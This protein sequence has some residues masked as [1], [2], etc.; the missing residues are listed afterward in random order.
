[1]RKSITMS[2]SLLL[3]LVLSGP[4]TAQKIKTEDGIKIISNGSKPKPQK[5]VPSK[6][7]FT[8]ELRFGEGDDPETSFSQV[9]FFVVTDEGHVIAGDIKDKKVKVFD[10]EGNFLRNIGKSGQGPGEFQIPGGLALTPN[11]E[12]MVEDSIA[13]RLAFF[14]LEGEFIKNVSMADK[15]SLLNL[16]LDADGNYLGRQLGMEDQKMYFEMKKYDQDLNPVFTMDKIEFEIPIPGSGVK[17][18]IM[19][20]TT[21]YLFDS[22]GNV[23]YGRNRDYEIKVFKPDGTHSRSIRKDF[24][25]VKV[26]QEDVDMMLERMP[27]GMMWGIDPTEFIEFPKEFP[28]FQM[29]I[30]DEQDRLFVRTWVK[31]KEEEAYI[32][33]VFDAEGRF[34]SQFET[35]LDFRVWKGDKVYGL[36][37]NEDG[38]MV[39]K[40]Y[41]VSWEN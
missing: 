2:L 20:M 40:R 12:L 24:K 25:P 26:T 6:V 27:S 31:G 9:A 10:A 18:D 16:V 41:R 33:D 1:M 8:E 15:M 7:T 29:F 23:Y 37:E 5:G 22:S 13:R 36:E 38:F 34:I 35:K 4:I 19:D 11:N 32:V 14:T 30:L 39:V 28:P 17:V 3:V 21:I